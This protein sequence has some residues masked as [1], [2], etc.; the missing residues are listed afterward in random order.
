MFPSPKSVTL[1]MPPTQFLPKLRTEA[2][3]RSVSTSG[4]SSW[5]HDRCG[6]RRLPPRV[7]GAAVMRR[8]TWIWS[9]RKPKRI[10]QAQ[11]GDSWEMSG[12]IQLLTWK[13]STLGG[14][15]CLSKVTER[16]SKFRMRELLVQSKGKGYEDNPS[17]NNDSE[18]TT[19]VSKGTGQTPGIESNW[20]EIFKFVD[21]HRKE[22]IGKF[23]FWFTSI[24]LNGHYDIQVRQ[25][26]SFASRRKRIRRSASC[27]PSLCLAALGQSSRPFAECRVLQDDWNAP[28]LWQ[29][30]KR[31]GYGNWVQFQNRQHASWMCHDPKIAVSRI[32]CEGCPSNSEITTTLGLEPWKVIKLEP[33][34]F[35][36]W[37]P[38]KTKPNV[39]QVYG[40][41]E[42]NL[43]P[44]HA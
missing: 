4:I 42:H 40:V 13:I 41:Q 35:S 10:S 37:V 30:T 21:G 39:L 34:K 12:Y 17:L 15:N 16:I 36:I 7:V 1:G 31:R 33:G 9:F 27:S 25:I 5:R 11:K 29:E 3:N 43:E 22:L 18:M 28:H 8:T 14:H 26:P 32:P 24:N 44:H 19:S 23:H 20:F 38:P 2:S 6:K